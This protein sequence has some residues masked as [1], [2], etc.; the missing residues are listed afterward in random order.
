MTDISIYPRQ[1]S[2]ETTLASSITST[3]TSIT[4]S[5]APS[6]ALSSGSAYMVIDPGLS[7]Q[8]TVTVT[9]V[10]STTLTVTRGVATYEGGSSSAVAH[11]GGATIVMSPL[12]KDGDHIKDAVNSKIDT[13]DGALT[14]Y[15]TA[16]AR[17]TAIPSPS[18]GM[19]YYQTD[20]GK[21]Y[22]YTGG[23]WVAR[24]S[25]GTFPNASVTVAGKVEQA[26]TTEFDAGTD[27]GGTGAQVF[28]VPSLIGAT[29]T[30]LTQLS[31][32]TNI[33]EADTFFGATDI[34]GAEAETLTDDSD[35]GDLHY[36]A[37]KVGQGTVTI[38]ANGANNIA[39][40]LGRVPKLVTL[41][42]NTGTGISDVGDFTSVNIYY[43]GTTQNNFFFIS[44]AAATMNAQS[45]TGAMNI[46]VGGVLQYTIA[47]TVDGTNITIT[48][49]SYAAEE[50]LY[51]T[52]RVE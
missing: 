27:T 34:S 50:A 8:E 3:D 48:A 20:T 38:S 21:F 36:H 47:V 24:E 51:Y 26:T 1:D 6:F 14:A 46:T 43:D 7:T 30:E 9:A 4:V 44:T 16:A 10:S 13:A 28:V 15:A 39:H 42:V 12:W 31:G 52:W 19:Q 18:N 35:A 49:A 32:T 22:D 33:A 23:S 17:A 40:G 29:T 45:N 11:E 2:Y 37:I 5:E 25:G 41:N